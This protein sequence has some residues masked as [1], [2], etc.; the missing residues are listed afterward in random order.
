MSRE[1]KPPLRIVQRVFVNCASPMCAAYTLTTNEFMLLRGE[2][3]T[4]SFKV[5]LGKQAGRLYEQLYG[6]KRSRK[7]RTHHMAGPGH[8]RNRVRTYP[9]GIL[10]QACRALVE[11][12]STLAAAPSVDPTTPATPLHRPEPK[13]TFQSV[14]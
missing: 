4:Q 8:P 1:K 11:A 2:Q 10:E 3:W 13:P 12:S 9:C 14:P 6:K 7:V 5:T